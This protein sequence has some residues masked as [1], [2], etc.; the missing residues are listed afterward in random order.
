MNNEGLALRLLTYRMTFLLSVP[1]T[2]LELDGMG[3]TS[4]VR[5][6]DEIVITIDGEGK[7]S[8]IK[9]W[10]EIYAPL[11]KLLPTD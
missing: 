4:W 10:E 1:V 5:E 9:C 7:A 3:W 8:L 11:P 6:F 2:I